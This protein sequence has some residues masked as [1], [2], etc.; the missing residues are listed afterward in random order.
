[1]SLLWISKEKNIMW[2][3]ENPESSVCGA[4]M[5]LLNGGEMKIENHILK[6][7]W[8]WLH[9]FFFDWE[10]LLKLFVSRTHVVIWR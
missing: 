3:V 10:H 6:D 4:S 1:M 8:L 7:Q 5:D 9:E 2:S